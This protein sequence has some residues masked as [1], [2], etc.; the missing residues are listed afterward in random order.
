MSCF[1]AL[2]TSAALLTSPRI[3]GRKALQ[4]RKLT[5][6]VFELRPSWG[7]WALQSTKI[8]GTTVIH[9]AFAVTSLRDHV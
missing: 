3:L 4:M 5:V 8:L 2:S 7:L 9:Q 1:A 6:R